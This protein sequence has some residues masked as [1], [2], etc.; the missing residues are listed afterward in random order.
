MKWKFNLKLS[1]SILSLLSVTTLISNISIYIFEWCPTSVRKDV[2]CQLKKK[3]K[4][5]NTLLSI[6]CR[7]MGCVVYCNAWL[8]R[9]RY[10]YVCYYNSLFNK[11]NRYTITRCKTVTAPLKDTFDVSL[12]LNILGQQNIMLNSNVK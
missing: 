11:R 3:K 9:Y 4:Q 5:W 2:F 8:R 7:L 6:K 12:I 10:K 1:N